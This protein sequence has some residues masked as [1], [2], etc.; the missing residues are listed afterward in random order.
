MP[1]LI[2]FVIAA[3]LTWFYAKYWLAD[4]AYRIDLGL[5]PFAIAGFIAISIALIT[6]TYNTLKAAKA[7]PVDSLIYE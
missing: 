2:A 1:M 4:Y 6:V 3:P 7:N 5:L